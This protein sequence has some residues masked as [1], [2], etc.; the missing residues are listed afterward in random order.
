MAKRELHIAADHIDVEILNEA[1]NRVLVQAKHELSEIE[2]MYG[3]LNELRTIAEDKYNRAE[4]LRKQ[5]NTWWNILQNGHANS[6][7]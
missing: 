3:P 2:R 4:N 1:L 5:V 7:G 6:E